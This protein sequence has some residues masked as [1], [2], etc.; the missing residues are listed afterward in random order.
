MARPGRSIPA[1]LLVALLAGCSTSGGSDGSDGGSDGGP[2]T[3][4][5]QEPLAFH[6]LVGSAANRIGG[7]VTV[8]NPSSSPVRLELAGPCGIGLVVLPEDG[9]AARPLWD[10]LEA[11]SEGCEALPRALEIPPGESVELHTAQVSERVILG[12]SIAP[13][14]Y[15]LAVR[16]RLLRPETETRLLTAGVRRLEVRDPAAE[17][18]VTDEPPSGSPSSPPWIRTDRFAYD[19]ATT[20]IGWETTIP[21]RW[22]NP[23]SGPAF[24]VHC[25]ET[26]HVVLEKLVDGVWVPGWLPF[27]QLCLSIPPIIVQPG[28]TLVD[29]VR[30]FG[31]FPDG[32]AIPVFEQD[33]PEG[34]YRMVIF[35]LDSF[36]S[37]TGLFGE[38][39]P[40]EGRVSNEFELTVVP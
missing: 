20:S 35:P 26:Y 24:L 36:R 27:I 33:D 8:R 37:P 10:Q 31:G 32:N 11:G 9:D 16:I 38:E 3:R 6:A 7:A 29:A 1:V 39:L 28:E 34:V 2:I 5:D 15:T 22:T 14:E 18:F 21:F 25:G 12:D 13:G 23:T 19:L 17:P 30:V 4:P 40:F